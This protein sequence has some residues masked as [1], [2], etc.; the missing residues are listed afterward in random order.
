MIFVDSGAWI[1]LSNRRDQHH[2]DA[3]IIYTTL[4]AAESTISNHRL[5][6]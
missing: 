3:V 6:D 5:C 2:D 1:A 4:K